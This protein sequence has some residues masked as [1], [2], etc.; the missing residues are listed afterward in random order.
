MKKEVVLT[1]LILC[2]VVSAIKPLAT[3]SFDDE[4]QKVVYYAKSNGDGEDKKAF[5]QEHDE[6]KE[7]S[8]ITGNVVA[9]IPS[10][11]KQEFVGGEW[12]GKW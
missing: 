7:Q 6:E 1:I 8:M 10:E 2:L 5:E 3:S 4:I 11:E 12:I 9:Q